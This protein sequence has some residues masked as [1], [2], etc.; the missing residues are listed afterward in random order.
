MRYLVAAFVV[1]LN[2]LFLRTAPITLGMVA[3]FILLF[4]FTTDKAPGNE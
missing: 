1:V 2:L 3:P 4:L